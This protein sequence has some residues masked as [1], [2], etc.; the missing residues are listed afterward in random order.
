[1][2]M[3]WL[4][5][6]RAELLDNIQQAWEN[7]GIHGATFIESSGFYRRKQSKKYIPTRYVLPPMGSTMHKHNYAIFSI[8]EN[9]EQARAALRATEEVTGDLDQP[10]KGVFAAWPLAMV[11]GLP[12]LS[13]NTEERR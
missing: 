8:V 3:V 4:V 2:Y 10:N 11:K 6:D 9:E 7:V 13:D 5:L 1:M 12:D